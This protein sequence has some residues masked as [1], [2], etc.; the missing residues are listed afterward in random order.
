MD[1]LFIQLL[2]EAKAANPDSEAVEFFDSLVQR[3]GVESSSR[4]QDIECSNNSVVFE[5]YGDQSSSLLTVLNALE[6][7]DSLA[8]FQAGL[9]NNTE[10]GYDLNAEFKLSFSLQKYFDICAEEEFIF[11]VDC[12]KVRGSQNDDKMFIL[13]SMNRTLTGHDVAFLGSETAK[14]ASVAVD[15]EEAESA[16]DVSQFKVTLTGYKHAIRAAM[17]WAVESDIVVIEDLESELSSL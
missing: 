2:D 11:Y 15:F 9:S 8:A 5:A 17:L 13:S 16:L 7:G 1:A 4:M 6:D 14:L 12:D 3:F 10:F